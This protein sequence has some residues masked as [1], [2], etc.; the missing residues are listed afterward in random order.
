MTHGI[1]KCYCENRVLQHIATYCLLNQLHVT[2]N[3]LLADLRHSETR[4]KPSRESRWLSHGLTG[5]SGEWLMAVGPGFQLSFQLC[6]SLGIA[7]S[8]KLT[9]WW[10]TLEVNLWAD[11]QG[12]RPLVGFEALDDHLLV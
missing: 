8:T 3:E 7:F 10:G 12:I 11:A 1:V 5:G 2:A 9:T 6:F 4:P